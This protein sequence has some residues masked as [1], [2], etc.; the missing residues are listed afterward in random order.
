MGRADL[1]ELL[2]ADLSGS[3][4]GLS[5]DEE[6]TEV[7]GLR[8]SELLR[9]RGHPRDGEGCSGEMIGDLLFAFSAL[10]FCGLTR[11]LV[12]ASSSLSLCPCFLLDPQ[13]KRQDHRWFDISH[14]IV[15][16][17]SRPHGILPLLSFCPRALHLGSRLCSGLKIPQW[18][19]APFWGLH[20]VLTSKLLPHTL[21]FHH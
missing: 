2:K 3:T 13:A 4:K 15:L 14:Q 8:D 21:H 1:G 16:L 19:L 12:F 11:G 7:R 10:V 5:S 6:R 18:P 20:L 9:G 17:Y